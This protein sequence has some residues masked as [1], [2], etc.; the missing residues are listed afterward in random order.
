[1]F[2]GPSGWIGKKLKEG[3]D[4]DDDIYDDDDRQGQ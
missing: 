4:G 2:V 1:M 3:D